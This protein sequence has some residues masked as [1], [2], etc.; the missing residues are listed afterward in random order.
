EGAKEAAES[1]MKDHLGGLE[2]NARTE[3]QEAKGKLQ[4]ASMNMQ[5]ELSDS[6]A[7]MKTLTE[8]NG[9]EIYALNEKVD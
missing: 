3:L 5:E 2:G 4:F 1:E 9:A 7:Y 6:F 8:Q